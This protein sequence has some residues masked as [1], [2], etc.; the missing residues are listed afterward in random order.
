MP[1]SGPVSLK[2][3]R[4]AQGILVLLLLLALFPAVSVADDNSSEWDRLTGHALNRTVWT[5][6]GKPSSWQQLAGEAAGHRYVL[7]GENHDNA[8]HHR[9]QARLIEAMVAAGRKPSIVLE[10][11]P[12]SEQPALDAYRAKPDS[13]AEGFGDAIGWEQ[14][15]WP[16]WETYQPI[17]E[18]AMSGNLPFLGGGLERSKIMQLARSTVD[19][20]EPA[21]KKR[22]GLDQDF[23]EP[24]LGDLLEELEVSHCNLMPRDALSPMVIV[25]RARDGS[26]ARAMLDAGSDGAVL[27][28]GKGHVRN[29]RGVPYVLTRLAE[30]TQPLLSVGLVGVEPGMT[31]FSDYLEGRDRFPYDY[32]VF[33]ERAEPVDYC[34]QLREQFSDHGAAPGSEQ[35]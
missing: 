31:V 33:T 16:A 6:Q 12:A 27:I 19:D 8:D 17:A 3:S 28:A 11:I 5:G 32:V 34:A 18:A 23:P 35:E 22:L 14:R 10:M 15:G 29:D 9:V 24:L 13:D 20:I 21:E 2:C 30:A 7:L 1:G 26:M 25:Q 4:H